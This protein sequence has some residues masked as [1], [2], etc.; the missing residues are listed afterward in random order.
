MMFPGSITASGEHPTHR[1]LNAYK[2]IRF[3]N[4]Y[5]PS[6]K[7]MMHYCGF[8]TEKLFVN[9]AVFREYPQNLQVLH[10]R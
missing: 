8:V 4:N 5:R 3:T 2:I 7:P 9:F 6:C 10:D 1:H